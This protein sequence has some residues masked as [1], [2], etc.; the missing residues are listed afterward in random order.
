MLGLSGRSD[1]RPRL[2]FSS[3]P[4]SSSN[5][6]RLRWSR[7]LCPEPSDSIYGVESGFRILTYTMEEEAA[8]GAGP[9]RLPQSG[10]RRFVSGPFP[11]FSGHANVDH[12]ASRAGRSKHVT[13]VTGEASWSSS[14]INLVNTSEW[15]S[16]SPQLRSISN[17]ILYY[18]YRRRSTSDAARHFAYGNRL[19]N[20]CHLMVRRHRGIRPL[21]TIT[22]RAISRSRK[23][24]L[25]CTIAVDIPQCRRGF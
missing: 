3:P 13:G 7:S 11:Q 14:V 18:S 15:E 17:A 16:C 21:P 6:F 2:R 25:L 4:S 10:L 20:M 8:V 9:A 19:G 5:S 1:K 22:M 12:C 23:C 24:I